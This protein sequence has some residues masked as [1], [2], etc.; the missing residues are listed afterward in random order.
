MM[1]DANQPFILG[2]MRWGAWGANLSATAA[3]ELLSQSVSCGL[4]TF[5]LADIYGGYTTEALFGQALKLSGIPRER[6]HLILKCGIVL[7]GKNSPAAVKNYD[8]SSQY[9]HASVM[10][11]LEQLGTDYLDALLIHRPSPLMDLHEMAETFRELRDSGLVRQFGVSNFDVYAFE[12]LNRLFPLVTNQVELS[13]TQPAALFDNT[14]L[15][16]RTLGFTPQIWS[17]LGDYLTRADSPTHERIRLVLDRLVRKYD[18][19]AA[20]LLIAWVRHRQS[21]AQVILGSTNID[22]IRAM[23]QS[24]SVVLEDSDWYALLE[25][26]RGFEMA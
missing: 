19:D 16:L 5:D 13:L 25:A 22:R 6:L 12:Q 4:A 14:L 24:V 2:T 9:I 10:R 8:L 23:I 26:S 11:S 18:A 20:Q 1:S 21:Q 15:Q 3:A 7:A 17:P